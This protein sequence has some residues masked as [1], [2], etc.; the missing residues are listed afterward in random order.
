MV[1]D[2]DESVIKTIQDYDLRRADPQL[3]WWTDQ[4]VQ[5]VV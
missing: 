2:E 4:N 1:R 5:L 3:G